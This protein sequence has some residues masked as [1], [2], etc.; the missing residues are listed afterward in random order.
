MTKVLLTGATGFIGSHIAKTLLKKGCRLLALKRSSS[1]FSLLEDVLQQIEWL[2]MDMPGWENTAIAFSPDIIIHSAWMGVTSEERSN[3]S[4]QQKNIEFIASLLAIALHSGTKK[5]I[6]LGSQAEYGNIDVV[7][8]EETEAHPTTAYGKV[9][10]EALDTIRNICEK[11]NINWYWLRIFS[12]FGVDQSSQWLIPSLVRD[13]LFSAKRE[14][15]F[16]K[17]EQIYS[18]LDVA[19]LAEAVSRVTLFDGLQGIYNVTSKVHKSIAS[20]ILEI[21]DAID[22]DY[23]LNFSALPYRVN[24][25]MLVAGSPEKFIRIYGEFETTTM[26]SRLQDIISFQ[27]KKRNKG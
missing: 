13:L 19:D 20:L 10:I 25:P 23:Q 5:F 16:T 17:G 1:S 12:V 18:Y 22:K 14:K 4:F 7:A 11:N 6:G 15:D 3:Y 2:D 9:K 26:I 8:T 21:R 27:R 24:Q